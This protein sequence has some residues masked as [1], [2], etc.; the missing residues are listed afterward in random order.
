MIFCAD[1][2]P[3]KGL[4]LVIADFGKQALDWVL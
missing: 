2:A 4:R 1:L 3:W